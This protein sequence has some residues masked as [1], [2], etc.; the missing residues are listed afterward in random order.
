[1]KQKDYPHAK[2]ISRFD[3]PEI[4]PDCGACGGII[5]CPQCGSHEKI[6]LSTSET[7][8]IYKCKQCKCKFR[9]YIS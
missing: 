3:R 8:E 4:K 9:N 1:M 2:C 7:E 5:T 6:M